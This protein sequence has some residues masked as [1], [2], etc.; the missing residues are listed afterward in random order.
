M[1]NKA[2]LGESPNFEL[3]FQNHNMWNLI[4][5]LNQEV[6]FPTNLTFKDKIKKKNK[7]KKLV[8]S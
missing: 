4:S 8:K 1:K 5:G 2:D 3:I 7:S 6:Q